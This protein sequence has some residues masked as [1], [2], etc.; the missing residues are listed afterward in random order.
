VTD[1]TGRV[2]DISIDMDTKQVIY[3]DTTSSDFIPGFNADA[4]GA[5]G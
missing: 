2:A 4:P 5:V 3:L 1:D